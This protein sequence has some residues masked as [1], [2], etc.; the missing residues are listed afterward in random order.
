LFDEPFFIKMIKGAV[1]H[2]TCSAHSLLDFM[3]LTVLVKSGIYKGHHYSPPLFTYFLLD[4]AVLLVT[5][6]SKTFNV[7]HFSTVEDQV[8]YP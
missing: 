1:S 5:L 8:P 2:A 7:C 4:P 6:F 3:A